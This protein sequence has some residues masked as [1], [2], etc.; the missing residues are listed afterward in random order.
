MLAI[1]FSSGPTSSMKITVQG[2]SGQPVECYFNQPLASS[3]G[4]FHFCHSFFIV[5]ENPNPLLG[6]DLLSKLGTQ[7]LLPPG[8]Y[9]C[10]PQ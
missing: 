4:D 1:P 10:L 6:Q 5:P 9:F 2:T 8:E 3:W 7:L